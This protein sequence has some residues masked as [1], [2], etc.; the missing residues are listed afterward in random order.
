M[1]VPSSVRQ[2]EC[3]SVRKHA[4]CTSSCGTCPSSLSRLPGVIWPTM[5]ACA[6][7][8]HTVGRDG[9]SCASTPRS[10]MSSPWGTDAS[11]SDDEDTVFTQAAAARHALSSTSRNLSESNQ[12]KMRE[13]GVTGGQRHAVFSSDRLCAL[14]SIHM[15]IIED[16]ATS[17]AALL[18]ELS[19]SV[20]L[21]GMVLH[22]SF[23]SCTSGYKSAWQRAAQLMC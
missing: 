14:Q 6:M 8:A 2:N 18:L 17:S 5:S 13:T 21:V 3:S 11:D 15:Q 16:D 20:P 19:R 9:G 7:Q 1:I 12:A 10:H 22:S 23:E 4:F